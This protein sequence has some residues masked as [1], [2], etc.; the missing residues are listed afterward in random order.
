VVKVKKILKKEL[1]GEKMLLEEKKVV[2]LLK[3]G[4]GRA[5]YKVEKVSPDYE[6]PP[7]YDMQQ[8]DPN[9]LGLTI[10]EIGSQVSP[11][12]PF[13]VTSLKNLFLDGNY[14]GTFNFKKLE[15]DDFLIKIVKRLEHN[16][17]VESNQKL[18]NFWN[19]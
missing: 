2:K 13:A 15:K 3:N 14:V 11:F 12:A 16:K 10:V 8:S 6:P 1:T 18:R 9:L 4:E 7:L 19:R 5:E 17:K